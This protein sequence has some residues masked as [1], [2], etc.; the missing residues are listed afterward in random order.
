MT[1]GYRAVYLV[2]VG[3]ECGMT[4]IECMVGF[5][6]ISILLIGMGNL[7]VSVSQQIDRQSL[8][9]KAVFRLNGEMERLVKLY[10][11]PVNAPF[12]IIPALNTPPA[13]SIAAGFT[14][15]FPA[16]TVTGLYNPGQAG[17]DIRWVYDDTGNAVGCVIAPGGGLCDFISQRLASSFFAYSPPANA[18]AMLVN[19]V[20]REVFVFRGA[21]IRNL[22]WLDRSRDIVG[23]ISWELHSWVAGDVN[24]PI[25]CTA[26][27]AC[28]LLTLYLDYPY[29]VVVAA[30]AAAAAAGVIP[31]AN[32]ITAPAEIIGLPVET[33][34]V[35]SFVG[36]RK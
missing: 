15:G 10:T 32:T 29:R 22:V 31:G 6:L 23:M 8:R 9:Q 13:G 18:T 25:N 19:Q 30:A 12:L 11:A 34:T 36:T 26:A 35:Q 4:V 5:L 21:Q 33:L 3:R 1:L 14:A 7:W 28:A 2:R 17:T 20:Y 16:L 27:N 24:F